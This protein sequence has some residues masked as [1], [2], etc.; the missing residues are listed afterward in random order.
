MARRVRPGLRRRRGDPRPEQVV[1]DPPSRRPCPTTSSPC[2]R[3][4]RPT[5]PST[6][7]STAPPTPAPA[8]AAARDRV[9]GLLDRRRPDDVQRDRARADLPGLARGRR[10]L[11]R[12]RRQRH[13]PPARPVGAHALHRRRPDLRH[14]GRRHAHQLRGRRLLAAAASAYV[15]VFGDPRRHRRASRRGSSRPAPARAATTSARSSATRSVTPSAS[16]T[17]A[18]APPPTTR[19]TRAG[20][21][22]WARPTAGAPRTGRA[23]S[24]PTPTTPRT[25]WRSSPRRRPLLPDDHADGASARTPDH[26]R[27]RPPGMI[28]TR[29]DVDSFTF[30]ATGRATLTVAGRPA[31]PTSTCGSPSSTRSAPRS[32]SSTRSPTPP[33]TRR[34]PPPGPS[35]CPPRRATWTVVVDGTG[36]ATPPRPGAT[37]TTARI[38][39]YTVSLVADVP[40][41]RHRPRPTTSRPR[42]PPRALDAVRRRRRPAADADRAPVRRRPRFVTTRLPARP[43]RPG[44]PRRHPLHRTGHRGT[45]RPAAPARPDVARRRHRASSSPAP[46]AAP[47]TS[48]SPP[49]C[50]AATGPSGL[51]YRLVV[52]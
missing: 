23:A 11:R 5:G 39:A 30:T 37:A 17:T 35:T 45:G 43:R 2:P 19:A 9:A 47:R 40:S 26:G 31:T 25:T 4:L 1:A 20:R 42:R 7:T 29:T 13:H 27:H 33:S 14:A 6:S 50:R 32:P 28:T 16:A 44:L 52:R 12:L 49:S 34:W 18:R 10:G 22:S 46:C 36:T 41:D 48:R 3:A 15:G 38:G 51:S 8:G 21:R 24:T